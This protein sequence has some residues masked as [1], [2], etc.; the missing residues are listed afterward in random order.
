MPYSLT[1]KESIYAHFII[2]KLTPR[3]QNKCI[4]SGVRISML[5]VT[6][7][8][9]VVAIHCFR[10]LLTTGLQLPKRVLHTAQHCVSFSLQ[11]PMRIAVFWFI[12][13]Q[14]VVIL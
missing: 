5:N 13:Q 14:I 2:F 11:Y 1:C 3:K 10:R 12:T 7:G 8:F 6:G 9:S 4:L